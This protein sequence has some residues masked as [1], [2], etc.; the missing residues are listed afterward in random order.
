MDAAG[1]RESHLTGQLKEGAASVPLRI[2][3]CG[4]VDRHAAGLP[5]CE[6][7]SASQKSGVQAASWGTACRPGGPPGAP[8]SGPPVLP[9]S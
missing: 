3:P 8:S 1:T 2:S 7:G 5:L 6:A 9:L 4:E